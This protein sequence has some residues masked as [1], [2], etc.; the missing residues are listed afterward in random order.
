MNVTAEKVPNAEQCYQVKPDDLPL[1]CP[2]PDTALWSSH[3]RV[4]I[5]F[6]SGGSA[7][8]PYCGAKFELE[9]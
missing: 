2:L 9:K 4:Y 6:D 8:C 1:H 7:A 3:P 5:Q